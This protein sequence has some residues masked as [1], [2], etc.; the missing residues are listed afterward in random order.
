MDLF[1]NIPI[2]LMFFLEEQISVKIRIL[3]LQ[4]Q[5]PSEADVYHKKIPTQVEKLS[6]FIHILLCESLNLITHLI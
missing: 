2:K 1:T 6:Q 4:F 5:T 3:V